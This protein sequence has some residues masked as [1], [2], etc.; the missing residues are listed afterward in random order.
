MRCVAV[1]S[2]LILVPFLANAGKPA[3]PDL[4]AKL[5]IRAVDL[6]GQSGA[7]I[8]DIPPSARRD[9]PGLARNLAKSIIRYRDNK[10]RGKN[11]PVIVISN[12]PALAARVARLAFSSLSAGSLRG[13]RVICIVGKQYDGY[14]RSVASATGA[15]L[16][17]EPLP[18]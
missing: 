17:V 8:H 14:L 7:Y 10:R 9:E 18:K 12:D 2:C 5:V 13:L 16:Q 15:R 4:G 1:A 6:V 3:N 11:D